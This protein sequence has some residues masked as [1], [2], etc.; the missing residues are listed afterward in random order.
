MVEVPLHHADERHRRE[1]L[2]EFRRIDILRLVDLQKKRRR[3]ADDVRARRGREEHDPLDDDAVQR[4]LQRY[5][6]L[7]PESTTSLQRDVMEGKPSELD[8]Q[9]GAVVRMGREIGVVTPVCEML[10]DLLLPQE[11]RARGETC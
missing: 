9:L 1:I 5:D 8:A 11:R 7:P 2:V 6:G 3:R 10:Y 4:T